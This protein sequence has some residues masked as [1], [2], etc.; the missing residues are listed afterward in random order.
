MAPR[1]PYQSARRLRHVPVPLPGCSR[2]LPPCSVHQML[3]LY[4]IPQD[5]PPRAALAPQQ[6]AT[7]RSNGIRT[8]QRIALCWRQTDAWCSEDNP[9]PS[10]DQR[11][12]NP[13]LV[14]PQPRFLS[15]QML[16]KQPLPQILEAPGA[17]AP[18]PM[19]GITSQSNATRNEHYYNNG[20][21]D[22]GKSWRNAGSM[23]YASRARCDRR[24]RSGCGGTRFK[25]PH[26][27]RGCATFLTGK[28][29][30]ICFQI[31]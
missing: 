5:L 4:S 31:R 11:W 2:R 15:R 9:A 6:D 22:L 25:L 17:P 19:T 24:G 30:Y 14:I 29:V 28:G 23:A 3:S 7:I 16:S 26:N 27:R 13:H 1:A 18:F 12:T 10:L 8:E 20:R 21:T